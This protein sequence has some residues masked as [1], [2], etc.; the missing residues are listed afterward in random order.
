MT[1]WQLAQ[2]RVL[3]LRFDVGSE[4]GIHAGQVS[5]AARTEPFDYIAVE[6]QMNG[7]LSSRHR[8]PRGFPELSAQRLGFRRIRTGPVFAM[9]AHGSNL[10]KRMCHDSRFHAIIMYT[11]IDTKQADGRP[12]GAKARSFFGLLRHD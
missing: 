12:T 6:A 3:L 4:N 5:F 8:Y 9:L 10:A 2:P 11:N 7:S 1:D